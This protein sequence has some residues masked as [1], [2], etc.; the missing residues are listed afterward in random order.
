MHA[1]IEDLRAEQAN[2]DDLLVT[3]DDGQWLSLTPGGVWDIRDTITHLWVM[4]EVARAC[5]EG[6]GEEAF[7]RIWAIPA[8]DRNTRL[9]EPWRACK[10]LEVLARWRE[11]RERLNEALLTCTP[12]HPLF[13]ANG[14]MSA[15]SF[16][17]ARLMECWS[18]GLDCFAAVG[19]PPI[20]TDRL[21]H[22]CHLSYRALPYAFQTHGRVMPAPLTD[23]RIEV[24]G[25]SG[26]RWVFGPESASQLI[27]GSASEWARVAVRRLSIA[28]CKTL[29]AR[30]P[31]AE[32]ALEVAQA[33]VSPD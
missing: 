23:L 7:A 25:P 32:Q 10:P 24:S 14:F 13:W 29:A 12:S 5:V 22:V 6:R 3:L 4:D 28:E 31:L 15:R 26:N 20:E 1:L 21:R 11:N 19:V 16:A 8:G 18:H 33:Y 17:T 27:T 2:L 30:G 9:I